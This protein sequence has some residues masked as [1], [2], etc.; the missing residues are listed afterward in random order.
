LLGVF[1]V[2]CGAAAAGDAAEDAIDQPLSVKAKF[3]FHALETASPG[4]VVEMAAYA[5][6][7]HWMHMP[8]EWGQGASSYGKRVASAAGATAIRNVFAFALDSTLREDPRFRRSGQGNV[9]RRIGHATRE[10]F[11]TRTDRGRARFAVSRFGSAVG[12]ACLSNVWYPD[13]LN[14]FSSGMEQA[15]ATIGLDLLG[16][17][18]SEFWPDVKQSSFAAAD[19]REA[20]LPP[21]FTATRGE[22]Q[23]RIEFCLW[24]P[25]WPFWRLFHDRDKRPRNCICPG[26]D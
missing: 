8:E 23:C 13:R 5:G 16:N 1:V 18:A 14:T 11:V 17:V 7:M 19:A 25:L 9:F 22:L 15:A 2:I 10:T 24:A 4:F 6:A 3:R 20:A 12:A 26:K 21:T